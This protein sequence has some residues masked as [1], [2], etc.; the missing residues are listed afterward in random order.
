MREIELVIGEEER[1]RY[2]IEDI[3]EIAAD[4][5]VGRDV[6]VDMEMHG[7]VDLVPHPRR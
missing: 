2:G 6:H 4:I 1:E 7:C 5:I 3:D